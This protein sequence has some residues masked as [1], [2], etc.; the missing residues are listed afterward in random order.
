MCIKGCFM[1]AA[2]HDV[3]QLYDAGLE[4]AIVDFFH[5][6][7]I[8]DRVAKLYQKKDASAGKAGVKGL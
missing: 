6:E 4:I 2:S 1:W 3:C 5:C 8:P 7:G